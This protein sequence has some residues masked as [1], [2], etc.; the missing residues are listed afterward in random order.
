MIRRMRRIN[1]SASN[2]YARYLKKVDGLSSRDI[3]L[4]VDFIEEQLGYGHTLC[5]DFEDYNSNEYFKSPKELVSILDRIVGYP[6]VEI[7]PN[8]AR[9]SEA[10]RSQ[11]VELTVIDSGYRG[12]YSSGPVKLSLKIAAII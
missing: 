7:Q 9:L 3:K 5:V 10:Y 11:S 1:E 2:D 6:N 8:S 4:I 12:P